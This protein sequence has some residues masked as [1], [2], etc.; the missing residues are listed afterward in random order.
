MNPGARALVR[1]LA[2]QLVAEHLAA[3]RSKFDQPA[4]HDDNATAVTT[5]RAHDVEEEEAR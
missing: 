1:F 2:E 4:P 5:N 3:E